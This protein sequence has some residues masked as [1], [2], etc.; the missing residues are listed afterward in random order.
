MHARVALDRSPSPV[1][2]LDIDA[3]AT[4]RISD[5]AQA[6]GPWSSA[7]GHAP[8]V[9]AGGHPLNPDL[10]IARSGIHSGSTITL[11]A[12]AA[13]DAPAPSA[14]LSILTGPRAGMEIPLPEGRF[15]LGAPQDTVDL[16]DPLAPGRSAVLTVERGHAAIYATGDAVPV[17]V[18][19]RP[20]EQ[21]QLRPTDTLRIGATDLTIT[22]IT[23][24]SGIPISPAA[25]LHTPIPEENRSL[26][27]VPTPGLL[28]PFPIIMMLLPLVLGLTMFSITRS[29]FS[30]MI[31]VFMPGFALAGF[32]TARRSHR[33]QKTVAWRRFDDALRAM[34]RRI[35]AEQAAELTV[36]SGRFP[37]PGDV[38]S[39]AVRRDSLLFSR[40]A[41]SPDVGRVR[42][43]LALQTAA[44]SAAAPAA[45]AEP[46]LG[47][48]LEHAADDL[49]AAVLPLTLQTVGPAPIAVTG[50]SG[51]ADQLIA[52][53]I[54]QLCALH[55]PA[56]M[57]VCVLGGEHP[58]WLLWLPHAHTPFSPLRSAQLVPDMVDS[59]VLLSD[60][61]TCIEERTGASR[62]HQSRMEE[63]GPLPRIVVFLLEPERVDP[64]T[65]RTLLSSG[66]DAHIHTLIHCPDQ[67]SVPQQCG[68][69][70]AIPDQG[71]AALNDGHGLTVQSIEIE[72]A[73]HR[74]L[75]R[76]ARALAPLVDATVSAPIST[77]MPTRFMLTETAGGTADALLHQTEIAWQHPAPSLNVAIGHT[78]TGLLSLDL[79]A[80]GPHA[81][82]GGTT[83]SGKSEFLRSWVLAMA[84]QQPPTT[85]TFL[86]VDYKGG[87]AFADCTRLPHSVGLVT[88][89]DDHLVDRVL[90]SL[91]AELRRRET[92]L[93]AAGVPD[94]D[95]LR[96][97][98]DSRAFPR[99]IIVVDEFAALTAE[100]P[101]FVDGVIDIAARGRS[102]GLHLILATQRPAGVI[103]G[104][105]RA[106]TALRIAL[107]CADAADST[108]IIGAPTAAHFPPEQPGRAAVSS[109]PGRLIDFQSAYTGA[110]STAQ[111]TQS[112]T[113]RP[114]RP[115]D[116]AAAEPGGAE[117]G[118]PAMLIGADERI[119]D[120]RTDAAHIVDGLGRLAEHL[121]A[122]RRP[123][124]DALPSV[125]TGADASAL[126]TP[127]DGD[128]SMR[129]LIGIIDDPRRQRRRPLELDLSRGGVTTVIGGAG[130][131]TT[132]ALITAA[133][134][135]A[136]CSSQIPI[137]GIDATGTGSLNCLLGSPG[138]KDI[139]TSD[140][141]ARMT[142]L[143]DRVLADSR[144]QDSGSSSGL[145]A[146]L[147]IDG[148]GALKDLLLQPQQET[149][150]SALTELTATAR[151]RGICIIAA[152]DHHLA[153]PSMLARAAAATIV[154]RQASRDD[155]AQLGVPRGLL[156]D[157]TPPGRGAVD[158][159][160]MQIIA[161]EPLSASNTGRPGA[162]PTLPAHLS[163]AD[164][165]AAD[166]AARVGLHARQM[167]PVVQSLPPTVLVAGPADSGRIG[168]LAA[169]AAEFQ[170][171]H[172]GAPLF[173]A[174]PSTLD[175]P[176]LAPDEQAVGE[177]E[178]VQ[179][180]AELTAW[181]EHAPGDQPGLVV[182]TGVRELVGRSADLQLAEALRRA[183]AAGISVMGELDTSSRAS[184]SQLVSLL[185][186]H[187]T[188]ILL[189]SD[190]SSSVFGSR[191]ARFPDAPGPCRGF[192]ITPTSTVPI[193]AVSHHHEESPCP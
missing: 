132:S 173:S 164:L 14:L 135:I 32:L 120:A 144:S 56:D 89:L 148:G 60:L 61:L 169:L 141:Q 76:A 26:P 15:T 189:E 64:P 187:G 157:D 142:R 3:D 43:G 96:A 73:S 33:L 147:L 94:L 158:G 180:A 81:L 186:T 19:A 78:G 85:T 39:A 117:N 133:Q 42:V 118:H 5:L 140:D 115:A 154:L 174:G 143:M 109:G 44:A 36:R 67:R 131:G 91:R 24:G 177:R 134:R 20:I 51:R 45:T 103:T 127:A 123:W 137:W 182:V 88:D 105:I 65:L 156:T 7:P 188:G 128:H 178:L 179:F 40:S 10:P 46:D 165:P 130:A 90:T 183:L 13:A 38:C 52:S 155:A 145:R 79:A 37:H 111:V 11:S 184:G 12:A 95:S 71:P 104:A 136:R 2:L 98:D 21:A 92:I 74:L 122:P 1:A 59:S 16:E 146:V 129:A 168:V 83:G 47:E 9:V 116:Q 175:L 191:R 153:L 27:S 31:I 75:S 119:T 4:A 150:S 149:W 138:V 23:D 55:S 161:P 172:P 113:V 34:R 99:L 49:S 72:V 159:L 152:A 101:D 48:Q 162:I 181:A 58:D 63:T 57:T 50:R 6:L 30:L 54:L 151:Q 167:T 166:G 192:W 53:M 93:A 107:R 22:A 126:L 102:L 190:P 18:N 106:N 84:A 8:T 112:V 82:V 66:P 17:L 80:Q 86:F 139:I 77:R 62:P 97:R 125:L 28:T 114:V 87:S 25:V 41:Q 170:R 110:S 68:T 69:I 108:D 185:L 121:P 176:G 163:L 29:P 193:L 70:F 124:L 171:L 100:M 160:E 35:R